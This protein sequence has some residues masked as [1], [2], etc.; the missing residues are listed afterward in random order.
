[1]KKYKYNVT[2]NRFDS[3]IG[4]NFVGFTAKYYIFIIVISYLK[5]QLKLMLA[6]VGLR[7]GV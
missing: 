4:F 2:K 7:R 3:K 5:N 1:M 6:N